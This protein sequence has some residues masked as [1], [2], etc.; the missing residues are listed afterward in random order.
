MTTAGPAEGAPPPGLRLRL[1]EDRDAEA[2]AALVNLI[3]D[4]GAPEAPGMTAE[5]V[6]R[7]LL[8]LGG[9]F[10]VLVA[11]VEGETAGCAVHQ[12]AYE[13]AWHARGRLL[14]DLAV[15]PHLRRRG[16][17]RALLARLA[18]LTR[19][20]GGAFLWWLNGPGLAEA[21]P[22]YRRVADVEHAVTSFAV[23]G[24]AFGRLAEEG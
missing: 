16:V 6:R 15:F 19:E 10:A 7:D 4:L 5:A 18:R 9:P 8:A 11:E 21:R 24:E 23:T 17:G 14:L 3:R 22:L 2:I 1:G 12:L 20:E 13:C